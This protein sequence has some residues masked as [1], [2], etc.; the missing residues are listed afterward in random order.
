MVFVCIM[1]GYAYFIMDL[2]FIMIMYTNVISKLVYVLIY[3]T[4]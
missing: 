2:V 1:D 3:G 4:K